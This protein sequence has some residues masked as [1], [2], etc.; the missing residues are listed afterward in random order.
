MSNETAVVPTKTFEEKMTDKI[1][2]SIG[3]LID[4]EALKVLVEKGIQ[5]AFF[6]PRTVRKDQWSTGVQISLME[7]IV[8]KLLEEQIRLAATEF[9]TSK[10]DEIGAIVHDVLEKGAGDMLLKAITGK[11][12]GDLSVM[13]NMILNKMRNGS[14]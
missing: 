4:P 7:E 3:D 14:F 11:F 5:K 2:D 9:I 12:A 13:E 1:K 10:A 6:E 8:T